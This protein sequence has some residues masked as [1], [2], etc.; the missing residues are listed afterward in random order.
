MS[1]TR[2]GRSIAADVPMLRVL[3]QQSLKGEI[4]A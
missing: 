3:D 4:T 2:G 1:F